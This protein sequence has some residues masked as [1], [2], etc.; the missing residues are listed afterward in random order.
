MTILEFVKKV[1][2]DIPVMVFSHTRDGSTL[3]IENDKAGAI[4]DANDAYFDRTV[5]DFFF[6][7]HYLRLDVQ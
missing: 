2:P 1:E 4:A 6:C 5:K 7:R 3:L